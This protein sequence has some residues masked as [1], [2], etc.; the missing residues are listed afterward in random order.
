MSVW[1]SFLNKDENKIDDD[2]Q[3]FNTYRLGNHFKL[4]KGKFFIEP[5][6]AVTHRPYHTEMPESF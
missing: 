3:I 6:I 5:S 1:Q 2:F 4:F